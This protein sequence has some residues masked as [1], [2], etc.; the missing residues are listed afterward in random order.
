MTHRHHFRNT[1]IRLQAGPY[2]WFSAGPHVDLQSC[3]LTV[4][5]HRQSS[6]WYN[7]ATQTLPRLL[8]FRQQE[9]LQD[10]R[11]FSLR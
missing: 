7:L 8:P 4:Y 1:E 11:P 5:L 2:S 3:S 6:Y 10:V 9:F